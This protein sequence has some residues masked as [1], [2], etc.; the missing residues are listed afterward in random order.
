M[1]DTLE[2]DT[3]DPVT[4]KEDTSEPA[5]VERRRFSSTAWSFNAR[6]PVRLQELRSLD[7]DSKV[8]SKET[9]KKDTPVGLRTRSKIQQNQ[10]SIARKNPKR[11]GSER[12]TEYKMD[13]LLLQLIAQTK[14]QQKEMDAM[15]SDLKK[16][17]EQQEASIQELKEDIAKLH[18]QF[19]DKLQEKENIEVQSPISDPP[20]LVREKPLD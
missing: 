18:K 4:P 5:K 16:G 10:H 13:E 6:T 1:E 12:P 8:E 19:T 20:T 17:L 9:A 2:L 7:M 14:E 15:R 3:R 11:G